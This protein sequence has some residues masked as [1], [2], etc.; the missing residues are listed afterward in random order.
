MIR[1]F[2]WTMFREISLK[3]IYTV[4]VRY[5]RFPLLTTPAGLINAFTFHLPAFLIAFKFGAAEAGFLLM[6]QRLLSVPEALIGNSAT[7]VFTGQAAFLRKDNPGM[8]LKLFRSTLLKLGKVSI[9]LFLLGYVAAPALL[10]A[11][12]GAEWSQASFYFQWLSIF[13]LLQVLVNPISR[14]F[15]I[16][17]Q[18]KLQLLSEIIRSTF[19][20]VSS[21]VIF[22]SDMS[23]LNAIAILSVTGT[24][25][26]VLHGFLSWIAIQKGTDDD[27]LNAMNGQEV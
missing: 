12:L 14:I 7:Q 9:P 2:K 1:T 26:Y 19:I 25:G 18:Q 23:P 17:E 27:S 15:Q 13:Y 11:L 4:F 8:V 20:A 24:A 21:L 16:Y 22:Y 6:A 3:E 5:K 10:P